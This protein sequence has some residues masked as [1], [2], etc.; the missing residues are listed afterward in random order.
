M[1]VP[2]FDGAIFSVEWKDALWARFFMKRYDAGPG[3]AKPSRPP[4]VSL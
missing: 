2:A 1:F 4:S 3:A